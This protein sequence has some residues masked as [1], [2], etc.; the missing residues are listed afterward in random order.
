[1]KAAPRLATGLARD[2]RALR[3]VDPRRARGARAHGDARAA[4]RRRAHR[5]RRDER[6]ARRDERRARSSRES[7]A[8]PACACACSTA[9]KKR[10]SASAARVAHFDMGVG[11]TVVDRH[12]RR[13]A[14]ARAQRRGRDRATRLAALRRD[15]PDRGV[16]R[17]RRHAEGACGSCASDVATAF[18]TSFRCATG[19]ARSS[20]ARAARSRTSPG[21]I[22]RVREFSP[23]DRC[24]RARIPRADLEHILDMLAEMTP[25]ERRAVPGLNPERADIIVAGIAVAAE[26]LRRA[27]SA[28]DR[29]VALRDSRRTA[30]RG[31][32]RRADRRRPGRSARALGA[33]VRRSAATSRSRTRRTCSGSR[34][35]LFDALGERLGL[36]RGRSRRRSSDAALLH[37]AGYHISYERHHKHSYHLILHADLLGMPPSE[38]VVVANVARYHRGSPPKKKHRNFGVLD[39]PLRRADQAAVGDPAR[40]RRLRSRPRER[41]RRSQGAL[42]AARASASRRCRATQR[43]D[44]CGSRCGARIASRSCSR[45]SR[46]CRWRSSRRTATCSRRATIESGATRVELDPARARLTRQ[47]AS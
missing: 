14:R 23:R 17:R 1:M 29:R 42:D 43:D 37:D 34:S 47:L 30:A 6:G 19:A 27:R 44:A 16:L 24:T 3:R 18:A 36:R 10:G 12:R 5:R 26:V 15:S 8:R 28:R 38:Q 7:S 31:G 25:D 41:G 2:R 9:T 39:K 40:R 4:A 21:S 22:S 35:S 11:R 13:L 33:R 20:S 45:S 46:A 32:A